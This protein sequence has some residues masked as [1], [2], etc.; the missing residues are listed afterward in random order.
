MCSQTVANTTPTGTHH[1]QLL[2]DDTQRIRDK[3]L[4]DPP[5]IG[6]SILVLRLHMLDKRDEIF[7][8]THANHDASLL[9]TAAEKKIISECLIA[10]SDYAKV[11]GRHLLG[12]FNY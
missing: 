9:H 11:V 3:F 7:W 10:Q 6:L 4:N 5:H 8:P 1:C 2:S 12:G